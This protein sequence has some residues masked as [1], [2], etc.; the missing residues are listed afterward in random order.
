M[1][2]SD[3]NPGYL[4]ISDEQA[5]NWVLEL[6]EDAEQARALCDIQT[7]AAATRKQHYTYLVKHGSVLGM[8]TALHRCGRLSDVA[9]NEL[10]AREMRTMLPTTIQ[11]SRRR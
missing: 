5:L 10:R 7:D 1:A 2:F 11:T 3:D 9:V 4:L 6:I 8:I